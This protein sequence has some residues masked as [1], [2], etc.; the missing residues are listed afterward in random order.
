MRRCICL[1]ALL[2]LVVPAVAEDS[3]ARDIVKK[4]IKAMGQTEDR[5]VKAVTYK[6]N[7]TF[8]GMGMELPFSGTWT[9]EYPNKTRIEITDFVT[10]VVDGKQGWLSAMGGTLD[11]PEDQLTEQ[12]ES[13]HADWAS[14]I[15]PLLGKDFKLSRVGE[16]KVDDV[17]VVTIKA[18][19]PGRRDLTLHFDKETRLL[20]KL[21]QKVKD[22]S[23]IEVNQETLIQAYGQAGPVKVPGKLLIKRDGQKYLEAEITDYKYLDKV[24]ED[25]FRRP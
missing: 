2:G 14:E 6:A 20:R 25:T 12:L 22:D 21:E 7:G 8:Y 9:I 10:I 18:S 1:V 15:V 11:L 4:A 3:D 13:I 16:G 24:P 19:Y 5:S 17:P 23:G